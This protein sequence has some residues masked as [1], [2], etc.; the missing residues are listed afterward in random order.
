MERAGEEEVEVEAEA[1]APVPLSDGERLIIQDTWAKVYLNSEDVGVAI[2]LRL[3][4]NSPSS[5]RLFSQFRDVEDPLELERSSQ[6]RQHALMV[7]KA[8][9]TVVENIHNDDKM[10]SVLKSVSKVHAIRHNVDPGYFK[11]LCVAIIEV[12]GETYPEVVTA[13]VAAAWTKLLANICLKV[14]AVYEE[15]GWTSENQD[16][17]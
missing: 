4:S 17:H 6:L 1:E 5:K 3:F 15:L 16:H 2:L 14:A 13:E 8:I 11:I 12:L 10:A 7:M 9:N